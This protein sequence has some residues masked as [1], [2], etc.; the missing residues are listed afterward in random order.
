MTNPH[1]AAVTRLSDLSA[2]QA[3]HWCRSREV[4]ADEALRIW[5]A[6]DGSAALADSIWYNDDF[7]PDARAALSDD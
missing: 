5:I 3:E 4:S 6:A 1:Y 7:W 2:E